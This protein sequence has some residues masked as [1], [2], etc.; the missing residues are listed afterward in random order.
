M[1]YVFDNAS[2]LARARLMALADVHD[3][4]TIRHLAARGVQEGWICLEVGAGLGTI[5][6]WLSG[7]WARAWPRGRD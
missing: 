7:V 5:T 2:P 6:R 1:T 3:P 4:G